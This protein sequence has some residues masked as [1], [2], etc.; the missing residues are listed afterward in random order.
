MA[1]LEV[2]PASKEQLIVRLLVFVGKVALALRSNSAFNPKAQNFPLMSISVMWLSGL[3]CGFQG[4]GRAM[5]RNEAVNAEIS[6]ILKDYADFS[7]GGAGSQTLA[8]DIFKRFDIDISEGVTILKALQGY[9][10]DED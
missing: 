10:K 5:L 1:T 3:L 4:L 2:Y 8:T 7:N 6:R 9:Y